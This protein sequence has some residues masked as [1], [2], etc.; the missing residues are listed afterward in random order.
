MFS[1]IRSIFKKHEFGED[2][3][4]NKG[5]LNATIQQLFQINGIYEEEDLEPEKIK[6]MLDDIDISY[7]VRKVSMGVS[8]RDW[9]IVSLVEEEME[10]N[11]EVYQRLSRLNVYKFI[12]QL[13]K[14]RYYGYGGFELVWDEGY[15]LKEL[16]EIPQEYMICEKGAWSVKIGDKEINLDD[17]LKYIVVTYN[18]SLS[19][20]HGKSVLKPIVGTYEAKNSIRDKMRAIAE[21]YGEV[22]TVFA[23]DGNADEDDIKARAEQ[24]KNMKGRSVVAIP[25]WDKSLKD[26][27]HFINLADLKTEI[28][29]N[30]EDRWKGEISKY[31]LGADYSGS[32]SG[33]GSFSR[34]K[35]QQVEQE[36]Q[37]EEILKFIRESF[38]NLIVADAMMYGYNSEDFYIKFE[39]EK[40]VEEE[41][42]TNKAKE[43]VNTQ[44]AN[45][46]KTLSEAG[47]E[48]SPQYV[49]DS[50]GIPIEV[51]TK[52]ETKEF[53]RGRN[54]EYK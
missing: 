21:R 7:A 52:K 43:E 48:L 14:S 24:L 41:S 19:E 20:V 1:K 13:D 29:T 9:E 8:S 2:L 12:K 30:L 15:N 5:L 39:K 35:L 44:K 16:V 51:I 40:T 46:I 49:S 53:A 27:V 18:D 45:T 25:V 38:Q 37:E 11:K 54:R 6:K 3:R 26:S 36:K 10:K 47:Y 42:K 32:N 34:D 50:L 23:Y 4:K 33:T 31:I 22:I 28:H 17:P